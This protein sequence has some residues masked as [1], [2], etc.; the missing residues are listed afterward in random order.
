[1]RL[2]EEEARQWSLKKPVMST[3]HDINTTA[4]ERLKSA[5]TKRGIWNNK[6]GV[7]PGMSWKHEEPFEEMLR[8]RLLQKGLAV[9]DPDEG[10]PEKAEE[11]PRQI[12]ADTWTLPP[13]SIFGRDSVSTGAHLPITCRGG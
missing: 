4:Y 3:P 12:S 10:E 2:L 7:L 8:E 6:W 13:G 9:D 5:W 1:M 11:A